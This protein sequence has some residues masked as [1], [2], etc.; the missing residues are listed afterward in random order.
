MVRAYQRLVNKDLKGTEKLGFDILRES[1][2]SPLKVMALNAGLSP[3]LILNKVLED[4]KVEIGINIKTGEL[5]D[6]YEAGIIDP[7]KVT[8]SALTNA[9]SAVSV[10]ISSGH[11]IIEE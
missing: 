5:V 11:A 1:L 10:L 2:L 6:M 3:D 9:K 7:V 8:K 4:E